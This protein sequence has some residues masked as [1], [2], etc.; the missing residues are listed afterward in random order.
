MIPGDVQPQREPWVIARSSAA[1]PIAKAAPP[2]QSICACTNC[3]RSGTT[4]HA[5]IAAIAVAAVQ[6]QKTRW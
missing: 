6:N 5:A 1:S 3:G 2:T 4:T